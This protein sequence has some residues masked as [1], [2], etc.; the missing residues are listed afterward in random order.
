MLYV[1]ACFAYLRIQS[2]DSF[3]M[4]HMCACIH[5]CIQTHHTHARAHTHTHTHTHTLYASVCFVHLWTWS[6]DSLRIDLVLGC[7]EI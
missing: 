3:R 4:V 5:A 1:S 2:S 7:D 6:S